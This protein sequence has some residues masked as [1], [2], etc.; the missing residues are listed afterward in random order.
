LKKE[1]VFYG[2]GRKRNAPADNIALSDAQ[3][4]RLIKTKVTEIHAAFFVKHAEELEL[5]ARAVFRLLRKAVSEMGTNDKSKYTHSC[6][7]ETAC[8]CC[9]TD[10]KSA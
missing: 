2:V 5:V 10:S 1:L 6:W 7:G 4:R 9:S 3:M 8:S